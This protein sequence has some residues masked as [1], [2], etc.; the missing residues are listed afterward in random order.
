MNV[1]SGS[2]SYDPGLTLILMKFTAGTLTSAAVNLAPFK[3]INVMLEQLNTTTNIQNG[4]L[5]T[6]AVSS[7]NFG[8]IIRVNREH[9]FY[10]LLTELLFPS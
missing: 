1:V 7:F 10:K 5:D 2:M 3:T 6:L 4:V 9:P 8:E